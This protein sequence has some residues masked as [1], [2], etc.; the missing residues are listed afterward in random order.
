MPLKHI[1][2]TNKP[3]NNYRPIHNNHKPNHRLIHDHHNNPQTYGYPYF[4]DKLYYV[5]PIIEKPIIENPNNEIV[6]I[7]IQTNQND[8]SKNYKTLIIILIF[9]VIVIM[10]Y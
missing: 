5:L 1:P 2:N 4:Y 9:I 7:T 6:N 8:E 10:Y 3:H